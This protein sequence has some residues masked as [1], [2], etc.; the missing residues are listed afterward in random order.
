MV[1]L[2]FFRVGQDWNVIGAKREPL[3]T[4]RIVPHWDNR[5]RP[6]SLPPLPVNNEDSR[7]IR[8]PLHCGLPC[9]AAVHRDRLPRISW[10]VD[11]TADNRRVAGMVAVDYSMIITSRIVFRQNQ[12][13][14]E[15]MDALHDVNAHV[16]FHAIS[17]H[18]ANG[19]TGFVQSAKRYGRTSAI[20]R[21]VTIDG[22]K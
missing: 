5:S 21:V 7:A 15:Y 17:D 6:R 4:P 8:E 2:G 22:N 19:I 16:V 13:R 1:Q 12:R 14:F 18:F 3:H 11:A 10:N 9:L 20:G